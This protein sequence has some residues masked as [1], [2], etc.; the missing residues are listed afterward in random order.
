MR[1]A[2]SEVR[3]LIVP[4]RLAGQRIDKVLAVLAKV[5][6]SVAKSYIDTDVATIAG[7]AVRPSD[8]ARA[9][10]E[11]LIPISVQ[12]DHVTA[13]PEV[14]FDVLFEDEDLAVIAKPPGLVVHR[15]AGHRAGTLVNGLVAR[16]PQI[17]GVGENPRWGIVH[18][19]DRDTSGALVVALTDRAHGRLS[20]MIKTREVNRHYT[21]LVSG[22]FPI[23]RGTV[24]API[25]RDPGS[26]TK[27]AVLADGKFARTHY[28]R[29]AEWPERNVS[30]LEIRLETGRTHQIRV[31]LAAIDHSVIGDSVY[32]PG[33]DLVSVPRIFLHA[34]RLAF[35]HP[36][37]GESLEIKAP[38]PPDLESALETLDN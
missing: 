33:P 2:M 1:L 3:S 27:M 20:S 34:E 17:V 7:L 6:R 38:L 25:G 37:T 18:R 15:G 28:R 9:G 13:D 30:L 31:H 19:L 24:E 5:P 23:E 26:S 29:I 35:D 32:R 4:E 16:Y 22:L 8:K 21:A 14:Q 10:D 12:D 36:F 11:I